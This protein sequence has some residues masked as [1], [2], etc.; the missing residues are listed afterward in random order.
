[1]QNALVLAP[2]R[3][4]PSGT[5]INSVPALFAAAGDKAADRFIE[6]FTANIRNKNTRTAYAIAVKRFS[7]WC[8]QHRLALRQLRPIHFGTYIEELGN[9]PD[10]DCRLSKP[11]VKQH[12]A[13]IK[14]LFDYLVTGQIVEH[15]PAASVRGPK[16]TVKKGKTP[17]LN[18]DEARA[19][20]AA[21]APKPSKEEEDEEK[22][23]EW[24]IS[25]L[26]DRALIGV[27]VYSFAR[28]SAVLGMNVEDYYQQGKRC[29]IRLDEKGGKHHEIPAHHKAEEFL[30]AYMAA[31]GIAALPASPLFR[32]IDAKRE[33]TGNRLVP[34]DALAMIKRRARAAGLGNRICCH[35]FRATGITNY[36]ENGGTIDV[37]QPYCLHCR[38]YPGLHSWKK[39]P[40]ANSG[41]S[42]IVTRPGLRM[43][44]NKRFQQVEAY[45]S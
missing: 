2:P 1:M 23:P 12:L 4:L 24:T 18:Q 44:V 36:L 29:W 21:M 5:E 9:H 8:E 30:D 39:S 16:Y 19:L 42:P 15:N 31:A 13:A 32:S 43:E 7:N 33:L 27:M 38:I 6:F 11:S 41:S 10:P 45:A 37:N 20:F 34:R 35:S 22:E 14:M 28:V 3:P 40:V 17:V 25:A 26:R